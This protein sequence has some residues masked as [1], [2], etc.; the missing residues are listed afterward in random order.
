MRNSI[1]FLLF[2]FLFH[3]NSPAFS[4]VKKT[5]HSRHISRPE[6]WWI[7][8]HIFIA[9]KSWRITKEALTATRELINSKELDND[10]QGGQLDAF[11]H[12]FWMASLAQKINPR[13][14]QKLGIAHE[15]GNY[16]D[17]KRKRTED[18]ILPDKISSAM[19]LFNNEKGV[20]LGYNNRTLSTD[21]LKVLVIREIKEGKMIIMYKDSLRNYLRCD[22]TKIQLSDYQNQWN[23]PKCLVPSSGKRR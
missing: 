6:V 3:I 12:S 1:F 15:K 19:D 18:G 13:K 7:A 16:I 22:D 10:G 5:K 17:F 11:R 23:I 20:Q 4:Q 21:S 9:H 2:I 8:G 14:A